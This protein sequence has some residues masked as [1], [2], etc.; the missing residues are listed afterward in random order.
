MLLIMYFIEIMIYMYIEFREYIDCYR[1][2]SVI[3]IC[4]LVRIEDPSVYLFKYF[5]SEGLMTVISIHVFRLESLLFVL[6]INHWL[7]NQMISFSLMVVILGLS[8]VNS[9]K[10]CF[11][12]V[13]SHLCCCKLILYNFCFPL[14]E[15]LL[16]CFAR[17]LFANLII[18]LVFL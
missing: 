9:L 14:L 5:V 18:I 6:L 12:I 10:R 3:S 4:C 1:I 17:L 13:I 7:W 16:F 8:S 11:C 2:W 15:I